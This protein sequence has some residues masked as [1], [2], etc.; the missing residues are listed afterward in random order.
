MNLFDNEI[1][2]A[3]AGGFMASS[4]HRDRCFEPETPM[5]LLEVDSELFGRTLCVKWDVG[6]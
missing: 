2:V 3:F 5:I 4:P 1:I 6:E